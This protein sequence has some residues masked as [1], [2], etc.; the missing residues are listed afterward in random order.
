MKQEVTCNNGEE[1]EEKYKRLG[2]KKEPYN[3]TF[4]YVRELPPKDNKL[5]SLRSLPKKAID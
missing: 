1:T 3:G 2:W 5:T 4:V